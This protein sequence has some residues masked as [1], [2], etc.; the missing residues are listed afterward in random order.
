MKKKIKKQ[1]NGDQQI[2]ENMPKNTKKKNKR[3]KK[4]EEKKVSDVEKR[5]QASLFPH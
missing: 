2:R 1:M 3:R 4:N 5:G